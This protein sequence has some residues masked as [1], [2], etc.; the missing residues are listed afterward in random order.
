MPIEQPI[1]DLDLPEFAAIAANFG[2]DRYGYVV[3]PNVDHLIRCHDDPKFRA[4]YADAAYVL[5]DSRF[6]ASLLKLTKG[7]NM[8]VCTG[9]DLTAHLFKG[10]VKPTDQ[11]LLIGGSETQAQKLATRFGL[12]SLQHFNPSMGF[13]TRPR[14]VEEVL[15][16]IETRSPFRFCLLAVGAPQQ[17]FIAQ[18]L[19]AR[20][21]ARG[22]VLCIGASINFLTGVEKRAPRWM[23]QASLEWAYRLSQDPARLARR[24]LVRGPRIFSLL[25]KIQLVQ[26]NPTA[27]SAPR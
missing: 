12:Q 15:S 13:I 11:V 10:I 18:M 23:Q 1:D 19:K 17:E 3:T 14:D 27:A 7:V 8:K 20:G 9:S 22:L 25:R 16:F 21:R 24:Y 4:A 5:M 6:L 2:Q 26:R